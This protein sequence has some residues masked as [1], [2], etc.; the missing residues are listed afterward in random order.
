MSPDPKTVLDS[1]AILA[2]VHGEQGAEVVAGIL[3]NAVASTVNI[4]EIVAHLAD[5]GAP[6]ERIRGVVGALN[7]HI[8]PFDEDQAFTAG[9]LRRVTREKGLSLGDRA[10]LA[11][12]R[13]TG[14][15]ALTADRIWA[16]L[17]VGVEVRLIR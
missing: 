10:C 9:A 13:Q 6:D 1:S 16:D 12:A 17:D 3:P 2:L 11:L 15:P 14:L 4:A 8:V 7:L 5:G